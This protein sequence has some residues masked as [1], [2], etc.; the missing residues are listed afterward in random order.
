MKAAGKKWT[1]LKALIAS[2][3]LKQ[4]LSELKG[5]TA[6]WKA[7]RKQ[8]HDGKGWK[9]WS[10]LKNV[11]P[12]LK[13]EKEGWG[14]KKEW[15]N[16]KDWLAKL[17]EGKKGWGDEKDW[18]AKLEQGEKDWSDKKDWF[19]KWGKKGKKEGGRRP[20]WSEAMREAFSAKATELKASGEKVQWRAEKARFV[21]SFCAEHAADAFCA[22][23][24]PARRPP[25]RDPLASAPATEADKQV[26]LTTT[27]VQAPQGHGGGGSH[28]IIG[29]IVGAVGL[30]GAAALVAVRRHRAANAAASAPST[31]VV[32]PAN[33]VSLMPVSYEVSTQEYSML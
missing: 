1:A 23:P 12:K 26:E 4:K 3:G 13:K 28:A 24:R 9:K 31:P 17:K 11:L 20:Q 10:F 32:T 5:E 33:Q 8:H 6:D 19:K 18:L 16:K 21:R 30:L 27:G 22:R 29:G 2:G 25:S 14:D 7:E 15:D